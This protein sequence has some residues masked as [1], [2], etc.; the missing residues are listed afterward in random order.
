MFTMFSTVFSCQRYRRRLRVLC[1]CA[2]LCCTCLPLWA[3]DAYAATV[4]ENQPP[5]QEEELLKFIKVF[6]QFRE[7]AASHGEKA[8]PKVN[9][10]KADFAYSENAA[11]WVESHG[12]DPAR[13]FS[14]MGR[15]AAALF[16]VAEGSEVS[17]TPPPDMPSVTQAD[18][19]LV[20]SHFKALLESNRDASPINQ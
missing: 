2:L 7:W 13:F 5:L 6:P 3:V 16:I 11:R 15:A 8:Y 17:E 1:V 10:G 9:Q 4:Y 18:L 12:W 20:R 19:N 14:V